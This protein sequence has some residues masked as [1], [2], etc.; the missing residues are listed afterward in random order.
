LIYSMCL[1]PMITISLL[2]MMRPFAY[3][4]QDNELKRKVK[5]KMLGGI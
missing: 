3:R 4:E 2:E 5:N 1:K